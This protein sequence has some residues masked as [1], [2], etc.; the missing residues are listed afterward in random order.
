MRLSYLIAMQKKHFLWIIFLTLLCACVAEPSSDNGLP[1]VQ[2]PN[3]GTELAESAE[4]PAENDCA[5]EQLLCIGFVVEV[6]LLEENSFYQSALKGA[7]RAEKDLL[8]NVSV[9]EVDGSSDEYISEINGI[10][11]Q[12]YDVIVTA[13]PNL[14]VG[15]LDAAKNHLE[16]NFIGIDQNQF[17]AYENFVG[18]N[19]KVEKAAFLAGALAAM[20]SETDKIG[21][22]L[23]ETDIASA[24]SRYQVGFKAGAQAVDADKEVVYVLYSGEAANSYNDPEWGQ[25]TSKSLLNDGVDVIFAAGGDTAIGALQEV[26][27]HNSALC[28][29]AD[30]DQYIESVESRPC[31]VSSVVRDIEI[32][33]FKVIA[34]SVLDQFPTENV[35]GNYKFAPFYEFD[36]YMTADVKAYISELETNIENNSITIDG[37]YELKDAPNITIQR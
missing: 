26:A 24:S 31:L 19:F 35:I 6:G 34:L 15:T 11:D 37:G 3:V 30:L 17:L 10:A 32:E 21:V 2:T 4:P 25:R 5:S 28:I 27:T 8:A 23:G 13:G 12:S 1:V 33:V 36:K 9:F 16:T 7:Q 29:G 22:V 20:I 14:L 18:I